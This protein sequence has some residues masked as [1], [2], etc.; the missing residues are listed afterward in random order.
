MPL[1]GEFQRPGRLVSLIVGC[2]AFAP[3]SA[4]AQISKDACVQ[5][6]SDAQSL[7]VEGA[8][9]E[10]RDKLK[11]CAQVECPSALS[12]DCTQWLAEVEPNVPSVVFAVTDQDGHDIADAR[13]RAGANI[14]AERT[15]GQPVALNPGLYTFSIEADGFVPD[16]REL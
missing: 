16:R 10:A 11:R 6:Y 13:V 2:L 14:V 8:L 7:R 15:D 9:L 3:L 5:A 12:R 4:R 1:T